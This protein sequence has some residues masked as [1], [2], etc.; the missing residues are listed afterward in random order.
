MITKYINDANQTNIDYNHYI[1]NRT[2]W[3]NEVNNI[4]NQIDEYVNKSEETDEDW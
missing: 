3:I 4:Y 1:D 2:N